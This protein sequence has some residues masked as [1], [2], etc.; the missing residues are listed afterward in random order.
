MSAALLV[1]ERPRG[2]CRKALAVGAALV[3]AL[4]LFGMRPGEWAANPVNLL[5]ERLRGLTL[6]VLVPTTVLTFF[7]GSA[8]FLFARV[9]S[10][11]FHADRVEAHCPTGVEVKE[12]RDVG[13]FRDAS[14]DAVVL[15]P[16]DPRSSWRLDVWTPDDGTRAAVLELLTA[17]GLRRL[18][19]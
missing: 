8:W 14:A 3:V 10:I 4:A 11:S 18:D 12:W 9:R 7:F 19:A 6:L 13:G 2:G 1:V 17:R 16:A 15:V 5:P